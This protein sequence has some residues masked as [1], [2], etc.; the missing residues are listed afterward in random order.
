MVEKQQKRVSF[1]LDITM[2]Y[3]LLCLSLFW[4]TSNVLQNL[5]DWPNRYGPINAEVKKV[6]CLFTGI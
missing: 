4:L 1:Q 6:G 5:S 3:V 2:P